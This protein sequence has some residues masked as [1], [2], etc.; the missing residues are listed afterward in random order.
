MPG[1][2]FTER[3]PK[4]VVPPI[5]EPMGR[6]W[7]QPPTRD[8]L[9]DDTHAVMSRKTLESL[10]EY[11]CSTPSGVYEGKMWRRRAEY[12]E[13]CDEWFLCWFGYSAKEGYVSNNCRKIIL[14]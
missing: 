3:W 12:R 8:I 13:S 11:S 9:I 2:S 5:T 7:E 1:T 4:N 14:V 6:Y 10:H